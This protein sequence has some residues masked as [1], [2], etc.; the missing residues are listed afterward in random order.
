MYKMVDNEHAALLKEKKL[1][2]RKD[3]HCF[4]AENFEIV[5]CCTKIPRPIDIFTCGCVSVA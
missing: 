2:M 3:A 4:P 5:L 1:S